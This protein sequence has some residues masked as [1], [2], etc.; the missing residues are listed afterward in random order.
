MFAGLANPNKQQTNFSQMS[1]AIFQLS[2]T[3]VGDCGRFKSILLVDQIT[4]IGNTVMCLKMKI[5]K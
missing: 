4:V 2:T 1:L 3:V 5:C